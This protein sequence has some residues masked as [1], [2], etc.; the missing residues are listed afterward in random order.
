MNYSSQLALLQCPHW[1]VCA[2]RAPQRRHKKTQ[3]QARITV[4]AAMSNQGIQVFQ[5][6]TVR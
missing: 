2:L 6:K 4:T 1:S 5:C 3:A